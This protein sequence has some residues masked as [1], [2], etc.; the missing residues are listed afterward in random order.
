M[1]PICVGRN[2]QP[3]S[4][5]QALREPVLSAMQAVR[6]TYP[7]VRI[8]DPF[9]LLC[10]TDT[11]QTSQDGRPFYFD[12]DHFSAYANVKLYPSFVRSVVDGL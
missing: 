3:R 5:L 6:Q 9:P 1:N 10:P 7:T 8:W 12:G 11:C 4:D 2:Q